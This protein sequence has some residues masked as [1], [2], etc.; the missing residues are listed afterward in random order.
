ML[1]GVTDQTLYAFQKQPGTYRVNII[2]EAINQSNLYAEHVVML[3]IW[4]I[5]PHLYNVRHQIIYLHF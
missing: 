4:Q 5:Q 1:L 2:T 3:F